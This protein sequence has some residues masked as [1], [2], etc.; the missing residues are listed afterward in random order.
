MHFQL[1]N[2]WQ[3]IQAKKNRLLASPKINFA[4]LFQFMS[5][6]SR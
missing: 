3:A 1:S 2:D 4:L 6:N 5:G